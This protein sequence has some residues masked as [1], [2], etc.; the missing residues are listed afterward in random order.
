M[1]T[2]CPR[3]CSSLCVMGMALALCQGYS[4]GNPFRHPLRRIPAFRYRQSP[5]HSSLFG[6]DIISENSRHPQPLR[7]VRGGDDGN[8]I[9]G[10][11]LLENQETLLREIHHLQ[12]SV[13]NLQQKEYGH[14]GAQTRGNSIISHQIENSHPPETTANSNPGKAKA[15]SEE[16][17]ENIEVELDRAGFRL[18]GLEVYAV[19]S[20]LT[21]ATSIQF[22]D[23]L[24]DRWQWGECFAAALAAMS[25]TAPLTGKVVLHLQYLFGISTDFICLAACATG[26]FTGLHATLVFS[27]MTVY[28]RTA[29]GCGW[30]DSF[31]RFFQ[32]T[33]QVRFRGFRSFRV[34]LYSFLVQILFIIVS[35]LPP[36]SKHAG[37][38]ALTYAVWRIYKDTQFIINKAGAMMF[39]GRPHLNGGGILPRA[40]QY[41]QQDQPQAQSTP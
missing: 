27:L 17:E 38:M 14:N 21:L 3:Y 32:S 7:G 8:L 20:A 12:L 22:F 10:K 23:L 39:A 19:V 36:R 11:Q 37:A 31:Q 5:H 26:M 35:R 29:V 30:D 41:H 9:H 18:D 33:E 6:R 1:A 4:L 13:H 34:S 16:E 2:A 25:S 24:S 15:R 40:S 28:G